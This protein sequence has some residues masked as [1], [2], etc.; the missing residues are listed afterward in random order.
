MIATELNIK[1]PQKEINW[2][3]LKT[4]L[5]NIFI[6]WG[7]ENSFKTFFNNCFILKF[8]KKRCF[9]PKN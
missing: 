7:E 5:G 2:K 6:I 1:Q 3:I 8:V 9:S 4:V